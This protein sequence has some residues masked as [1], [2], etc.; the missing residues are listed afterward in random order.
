MHSKPQNS[1]VV[2]SPDHLGIVASR[3]GRLDLSE[4]WVVSWKPHRRNR[5]AEQNALMW[6]HFHNMF[7]EG[8]G[9]GRPD[10]IHADF[11]RRMLVPCLKSLDVSTGPI[12][13]WQGHLQTAR[14]FYNDGM[15]KEALKMNE[16]LEG[17]ASTKWLNTKQMGGY[18]DLIE[19]ETAPQGL[20]LPNM[21]D[22]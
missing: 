16:M 15:R 13:D 14:D 17:Y 8:I 20:P 1:V 9:A 6:K 4:P 22:L 3:L 21:E 2:S 12:A 10:E 18:L 19:A 11:K 7:A 5:S